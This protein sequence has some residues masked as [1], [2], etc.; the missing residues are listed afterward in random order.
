MPVLTTTYKLSC[1]F[2]Q[3]FYLFSN[4]FILFCLE[5]S[6]TTT[7]PRKLACSNWTEK[8]FQWN[9]FSNFQRQQCKLFSAC[10]YK[11]YIFTSRHG[12]KTTNFRLLVQACNRHLVIQLGSVQVII[13]SILV[14]KGLRN[15]SGEKQI[16]E[17]TLQ[18][19]YVLMVIERDSTGLI[20]K[21]TS[22]W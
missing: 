2:P 19:R 18:M 8:D 6:E 4:L 13:I 3:M 21:D 11:Y 1:F 14:P 9:C 22:G 16:M 20:A 10:S 12:T 7:W 15:L 17:S 5:I